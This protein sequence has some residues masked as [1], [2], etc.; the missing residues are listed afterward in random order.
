VKGTGGEGFGG[1]VGYAAGE[2]DEDLILIYLLYF[3]CSGLHYGR[4]PH[5]YLAVARDANVVFSAFY[6][7]YRSCSE[8]FHKNCPS[9]PILILSI[10]H[11]HRMF[12]RAGSCF[13]TL[14]SSTAGTLRS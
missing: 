13:R 6:S 11:L 8:L 7:H 5:R 9:V 14:H 2:A 12:L 4:F 10:R 3:F 1:F